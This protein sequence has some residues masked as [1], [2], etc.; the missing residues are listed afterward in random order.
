MQEPGVF[1]WRQWHTAHQRE[2]LGDVK[3]TGADTKVEACDREEAITTA[4]ASNQIRRKTMQELDEEHVVLLRLVK[5]KYSYSTC[6]M[7]CV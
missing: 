7:M 5:K 6:V 3:T 2:L 4:F 1:H